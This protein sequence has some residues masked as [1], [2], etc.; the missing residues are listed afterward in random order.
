[1][2]TMSMKVTKVMTLIKDPHAKINIVAQA[3]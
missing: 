2:N 1:M 3:D